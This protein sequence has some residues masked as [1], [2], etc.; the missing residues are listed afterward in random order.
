MS[1]NETTCRRCGGAL[2][3][4][5]RVAEQLASLRGDALRAAAEM[6]PIGGPLLR[7]QAEADY[8]DAGLAQLAAELWGVCTV[9]TLGDEAGALDELGGSVDEPAPKRWLN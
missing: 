5:A 9:C 8:I 7:A 6:E 3:G 4:V 2:M 1:G